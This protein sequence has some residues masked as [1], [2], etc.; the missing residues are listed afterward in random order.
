MTLAFVLAGLWLTWVTVCCV[1]FTIAA[2]NFGMGV[3]ELNKLLEK[4]R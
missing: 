2:W 4:M 1:L 3:R